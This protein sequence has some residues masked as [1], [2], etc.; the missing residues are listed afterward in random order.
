MAAVRQTVYT[1][2]DAAA[3]THVAEVTLK[4]WASRGIVVPSGEGKVYSFRDLV[5]ARVAH[6][7]RDRSMPEKDILRCVRAL[8]SVPV[9]DF[10]EADSFSS[11]KAGIGLVWALGPEEDSVGIVRTFAEVLSEMEKALAVD[12]GGDGLVADAVVVIDV[13]SHARQL[14]EAL[15]DHQLE[16]V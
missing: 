11:R 8:A 6:V 3:V 7:L 15:R 4:H 2:K 9:E 5:L 16:P 10:A 1:A 13:G 14:R 12:G